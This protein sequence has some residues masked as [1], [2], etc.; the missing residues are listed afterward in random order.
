MWWDRG[1]GLDEN[2]TL[3]EIR[4]VSFKLSKKT[5][6]YLFGMYCLESMKKCVLSLDRFHTRNWEALYIF[7][8]DV[9]NLSKFIDRYI[10]HFFFRKCIYLKLLDQLLIRIV[11]TMVKLHGFSSNITACYHFATNSFTGKK[12][13]HLK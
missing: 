9:H 8:Q 3:I 11:V 2:K 7:K 13:K 10:E 1:F 12:V 6:I 5:Q 4:D